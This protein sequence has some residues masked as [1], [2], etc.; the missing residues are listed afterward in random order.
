MIEEGNIA[1]GSDMFSLLFRLLKCIVLIGVVEAFSGADEPL[2][3][4]SSVAVEVESVL[5]V[6][7][8]VGLER[9]GIDARIR[10]GLAPTFVL[11]VQ[12]KV[13]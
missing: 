12:A 5:P 8:R 2:I 3:I 6:S 4:T 7:R 1:L 10:F 11:A 13:L 9:S